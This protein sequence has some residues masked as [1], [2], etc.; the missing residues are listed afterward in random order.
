[1]SWLTWHQIRRHQR[2]SIWVFPVLGMAV[3]LIAANVLSAVE[4]GWERISSIDSTAAHVVLGT[5]AGSMFTLI[6]FVCSALLL[7]VQLAS[8]QLT[9]RIIGFLFRDRVVRF[10]L[11]FFVFSFTFA[12]SALL[13]I[14][15]P[16][17]PIT[18]YVAAYSCL[19]S[20]LVFL[21][22]TT[23]IGQILRAGGALRA[24]GAIGRSVIDSVYPSSFKG[25]D[26]PLPK[27]YSPAA[28]QSHAVLS[29]QDG[30]VLAFDARGLVALARRF[31]CTIEVVPQVGDFVAKGNPLFRVLHDKT[32]GGEIP[33]RDLLHS[34]AIGQE[35]TYEQ[36]PAL[37]FR[38]IVDIASKALSP[39][40]NDPTTAVLALDE[41]HHLLRRVGS[42]HLDERVLRDANSEVRLVYRTPGWDD[43]VNLAV[44]EIRL[45]GGE[46][47]QVARRLRALLENLIR[48]LPAARHAP[49]EQELT[50]LKRS[51]ERLF[52]EPE[53]RAL[54]DVSDSQGVGGRAI[55]TKDRSET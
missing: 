11:A 21:F 49:L 15:G 28:H 17:R 41:I 47:L 20:L 45:Y 35:R 9:P 50:L 53:D 24:V 6:V 2:N 13:R 32:G 29:K 43:F 33:E 27:T 18:G 1:M 37:P 38:I 51:S 14:N 8:A 54:A 46:S 22:L 3:A 34:I 48:E 30:S 26:E 19:L 39:A 5:L 52:K 42:R 25:P 40:I 12:L 16:P 7:I 10:S 44:T 31:D 36:D 55:N 4:E 23:H